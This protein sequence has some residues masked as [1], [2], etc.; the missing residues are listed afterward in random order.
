M[1]LLGYWFCSV[2]CGYYHALRYAETMKIEKLDS[3]TVFE[4]D[5]FD[6]R[7]DTIREN[8]KTHDRDVVVHPGS[9][10]ILPV[11]DDG[12][13]ALVR[14]YRHAIGKELLELAAGSL[15]QGED[16]ETGAIRELEEE[17]GV[18][19]EKIELLC[20]VYVSPGFLTEKMSI[21]LATGLTDVGQKLEG[22]E[23]ITVERYSFEKLEEMI[24]NG[25]I[26]DAKTIVGITLAADWSGYR[27]GGPW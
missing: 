13:V 11:F 20:S 1:D 23:N 16:P 8:G 25:Q 19:A 15:E 27:P 12:T 5:V 4:G 2:D 9:A 21:Y 7:I 18:R 10:V 26:D 6:V 22:D 24:K 14:Q 17:I 3:K